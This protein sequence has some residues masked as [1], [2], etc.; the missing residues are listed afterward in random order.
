MASDATYSAFRLPTQGRMMRRTIDGGV[1]DITTGKRTS[2][3]LLP[4]NATTTGESL[5][6]AFSY[7][8]ERKPM[9]IITSTSLDL[10]NKLAVLLE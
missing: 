10:I 1:Q 8:P 4:L 6:L 9:D 5:K 2:I 3:M 7:A